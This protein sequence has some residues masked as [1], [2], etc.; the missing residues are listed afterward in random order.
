[1]SSIAH[2]LKIEEKNFYK[3]ILKYDLYFDLT[4]NLHS[5]IFK[6]TVIINMGDCESVCTAD[7]NYHKKQSPEKS[8]AIEYDGR[9]FNISDRINFQ[10]QSAFG[11]V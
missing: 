2:L 9:K 7:L 1:M 4:V 11:K 8:L 5:F 3:V 6:S 10:S